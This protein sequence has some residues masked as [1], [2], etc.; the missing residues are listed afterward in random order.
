MR[1]NLEENLVGD[2]VVELRSNSA[3]IFERGRDWW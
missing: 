3:R 1:A 2:V